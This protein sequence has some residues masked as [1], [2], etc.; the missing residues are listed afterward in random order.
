MGPTLLPACIQ[1]F[2]N[3]KLV[4]EGS[5]V[6]RT[7]FLIS[8]VGVFAGLRVGWIFQ[9]LGELVLT[10]QVVVVKE[11]SVGRGDCR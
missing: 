2:V 1:W 7:A 4:D 9:I 10:L 11:R 5:K 6:E 3:N 8:L